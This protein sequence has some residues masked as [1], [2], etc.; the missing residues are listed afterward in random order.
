M[1]CNRFSLNI[2]KLTLLLS[3]VSSIFI[4]KTALA[5]NIL[6]ERIDKNNI[7]QSRESGILLETSL[8]NNNGV[9]VEEVY[10]NNRKISEL[11]WKFQDIL[12][13]RIK[14]GLIVDD[15]FSIN[16][17]YATSKNN[18]YK[19]R[20]T[21]YDWLGSSEFPG[22]DDGNKDHGN[23]THY[24]SSIVKA[25][26]QDFDI[27]GNSTFFENY[28]FKIGFRQQEFNF[29]D[30]T[31]DYIYSCNQPVSSTNTCKIGFRNL[32]G[33]FNN[34]NSINY[35]QRFRIPYIGIGFDKKFLNKKLSLS[36]FS[37]YS[38]A[39]YAYDRDNHVKR[40][41]T[42]ERYFKNGKYYNIGT[43]IGYN[44]HDNFKINLGYEYTQ[45]P[46]ITGD[47]RYSFSDGNAN[48][49]SK[50]SAGIANNYQKISLGL[51]YLFYL[52]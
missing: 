17:S 9:A 2:I 15:S 44:F 20:M 12:M 28:S 51:S 18:S 33:N 31:Q 13:S 23:W 3:I 24:S 30:K 8:E 39:V 32:S 36:V 16:L 29:E 5:E 50:N 11:K 47:S 45:I 43:N 21:D 25:N 48:F 22:G 10:S 52:N 49:S 34:D 46:L 41:M 26:M 38:S 27:N 37:A 40:S 1:V 7:F 6:L 42:I 19:S 4:T 35:Y 14:L